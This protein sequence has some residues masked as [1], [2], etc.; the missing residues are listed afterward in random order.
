M[1]FEQKSRGKS[2]AEI[3]VCPYKSLTTLYFLLR[4]PQRF[5]A[6]GNSHNE[7]CPDKS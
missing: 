3:E 1:L 5:L 4:F 2:S 6:A 7:Y